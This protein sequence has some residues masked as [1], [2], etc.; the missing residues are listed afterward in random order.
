MA[1]RKL[2]NSEPNLRKVGIGQANML[3]HH[4]EDEAAP[5]RSQCFRAA[6]V[7]KRHDGSRLDRQDNRRPERNF[8]SK[9]DRQRIKCVTTPNDLVFRREII[10]AFA[11][12][13][14]C[15]DRFRIA[16]TA[17]SDICRNRRP[18][19]PRDVDERASRNIHDVELAS[20]HRIIRVR[21]PTTLHLL[22]RAPFFILRQRR[23]ASQI[24]FRQRT[25]HLHQAHLSSAQ[26]RRSLCDV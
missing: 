6:R 8:L 3:V 4:R 2:Q 1:I 7:N 12:L 23:D 15:G 13:Q 14:I 19:R 24:Q 5:F 10:Q 17:P 26:V 9:S 11:S 18:R 16:I 21:R 22:K 20:P 25:A